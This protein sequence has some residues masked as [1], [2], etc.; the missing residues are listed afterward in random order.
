MVLKQAA[1]LFTYGFNF[2]GGSGDIN[3]WNPYVEKPGE[4]TTSQIWLKGG[5]GDNFESVESGWA[6]IIS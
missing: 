5:P 2:I 4:F 6:V 1:I 3:V